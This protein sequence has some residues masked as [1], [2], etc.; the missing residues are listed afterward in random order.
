MREG[1]RMSAAV[2]ALGLCLTGSPV[3]A[4]S[5]AS[6]PVTPLVVE[7][8]TVAGV[9]LVTR[10]DNLAINDSGGWLVE[11]D[12]DA[13]DTNTDQILLRSGGL[14]LRENDPLSDPPGATISSFDSININSAGNS[15][16]NFFLSGP[17][18][19]A[20]SGIYFGTT[21]VIQESDVST[22]PEFSP[23]T[24]YI[25]YFDAKMNDASEIALVASVDDPAITSTV[26]RALVIV[27]T[28]GSG[29][30]VSES[31]LAKEADF[32]AGQSQRVTDFGTAPHES[33]FNDRAEI[34]FFADL[35][36][37]TTTD[38]VI[39]LN[40]TL[41]A[42]EGSPS[43]VAGR[44]YET[45]SGRGLDL[46]DYGESA[47][48]ANLDGDATTDE[49][50]VVEGR[51]LVREGASLPGFAPFLLTSTGLASGPVGIDE[52]RNVLWFGD[53]DNPD[54]TKDTGLFLND[55]LIVSEGAPLG[56]GRTI[57]SFAN[58]QDA[59]FLSENGRYV[60]FE[61]TLDNGLE[62]AF[63]IEVRGP[64]AVPDGS[65][66]P[67]DASRAGKNPNG[68]DIDVSWDIAGCPEPDYNLFYGEL[69]S[70]ATYS[71]TGAACGLGNT[72]SATFTPPEGDLFWV[73]A[74]ED[75]LG[76][77]GVHGFDSTGKARPASAGGQCGV[78]AQLRSALCP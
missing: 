11:A 63:Q 53:W 3:S 13:A 15:G 73:I 58:G 6:F 71:Y 55:I 47:F 29:G 45:L 43:P 65:R 18:T 34:L 12:T 77:E 64:H 22:A 32:L 67:G 8:D 60:I 23:G 16:W 2:V 56:G 41:L 39:Y 10:I 61:A 75:A 51:E 9:G 4:S 14:Y 7:G 24:P 74:S 70:V 5:E 35:E 1:T 26:D 40:T 21:L 59:F 31:V 52:T 37:A 54:T 17:P 76:I 50:I 57:A 36:G 30:L 66:V 69:A 78:A 49:M 33:A 44:N 20:D 62:G 48:K 38:G 42:Q 68:T 19:N 72:G 46:N 25:G 27:R 28:D